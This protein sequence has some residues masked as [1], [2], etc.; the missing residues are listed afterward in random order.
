MPALEHGRRGFWRPSLQPSPSV[1]WGLSRRGAQQTR[2]CWLLAEGPGWRVTPQSTSTRTAGRHEPFRGHAAPACRPRWGQ[3]NVSTLVI[4]NT[5]LKSLLTPATK[6]PIPHPQHNTSDADCEHW[7]DLAGRTL[8]PSQDEGPEAIPAGSQ[9]VMV[10]NA[11]VRL[12]S[13][14]TIYLM[15]HCHVRA[16]A[17]PSVSTLNELKLNLTNLTQTSKVQQP[18]PSITPHLNRWAK[19]RLPVRGTLFGMLL[20]LHFTQVI[21]IRA[22]ETGLRFQ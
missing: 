15:W 19:K 8:S 16:K 14:N 10:S 18:W 4:Q 9:E 12:G 20:A 11:L 13:L 21:C 17:L 1:P 7:E 22:G 3:C 6:L 5:Y 2:G